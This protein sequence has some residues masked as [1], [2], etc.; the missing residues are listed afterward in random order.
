M[1]PRI[2]TRTPSPPELPPGV[3]VGLKGLSVRPKTWFTLSSSPSVC[4]MLVLA[5]MTAPKERRSWTRDASLEAGLEHSAVTPRDESTPVMLKL[6]FTEMGRPWRGP[7]GFPVR[8][9][10]APRLRA[11]CRADVKRGSVMQRVNC[12]AIAALYRSSQ[13]DSSIRA[14]GG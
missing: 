1:D 4:G 9:R 11:C 3:S 5:I 13:S 2:A 12:C 6:S 14:Y 10:W 8:D 7:T